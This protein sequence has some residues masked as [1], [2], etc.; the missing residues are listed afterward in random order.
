MHISALTTWK[1]RKGWRWIRIR[2][3]RSRWVAHLSG[4][5]SQSV[6]LGICKKV[7]KISEHC[8]LVNKV[9]E[10]LKVFLVICVVSIRMANLNWLAFDSIAPLNRISMKTEIRIKSIVNRLKCKKLSEIC[11]RLLAFDY[12]ELNMNEYT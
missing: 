4:H 7:S 12:Y 8:F 11:V 3:S 1:Q 2:S 6:V 9:D 10:L 5:S